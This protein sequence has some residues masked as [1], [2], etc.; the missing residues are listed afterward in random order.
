MRKRARCGLLL[1]LAS[2]WAGPLPAAVTPAENVLA[3]SR[4]LRDQTKLRHVLYLR[5][6]ADS[7]APR[8][9]YVLL[10]YRGGESDNMADLV[11]AAQLVR[12]HDIWV[13]IP[14]A[15]NGYWNYK[16][17][18]GAASVPDDVKFLS[19]VIDEAV[20]AYGLDARRIYMGGYSGGAMMTIRYACERPEKIAGAALVGGQ[21]IRT[22]AP[23][24]STAAPVPMAFVNGELDPVGAYNG[25]ATLMSSPD[26]A[27][28]WAQLNGCDALP[29]HEQLPDTVNDGTRIELDRYGGCR[30]GQ[31]VRLYTVRQ[32]GHTWPGAVDF[33]PSLGRTSQDLNASEAFIRFLL[34]FSR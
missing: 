27:A 16:M 12:D 33:S 8:A 21:L 18:L 25:D 34:S 24:C 19:R 20:A 17:L 23:R 7:V 29:V 1:I 26:S 2:V 9:A 30:Q 3:F 4:D 5:P 28:F 31:A 15:V 13:I 22:L 14:E 6:R 32:G 10:P 11:G